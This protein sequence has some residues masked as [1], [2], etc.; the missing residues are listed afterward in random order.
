[1]VEIRTEEASNLPKL[2]RWQDRDPN[3]VYLISEP[4][5]T[6]TNAYGSSSR[7]PRPPALGRLPVLP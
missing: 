6:Q 2:R 1:M 3:Y 7:V 5:Q 4:T